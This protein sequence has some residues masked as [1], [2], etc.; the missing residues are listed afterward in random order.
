MSVLRPDKFPTKYQT[1]VT[2]LL[3]DYTINT[4]NVPDCSP[5]F[6]HKGIKPEKEQPRRYHRVDVKYR[7]S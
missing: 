4:I 7:V 2:T 3:Y 6:V 1:T 5:C